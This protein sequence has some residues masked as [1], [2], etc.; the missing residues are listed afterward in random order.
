MLQDQ[1][2]SKKISSHQFSRNEYAW[3]W[4]TNV[5]D[6]FSRNENYCR[7]LT[8]KRCQIQ[9]PVRRTAGVNP[10]KTFLQH[11]GKRRKELVKVP[12]RLLGSMF[13]EKR[14]RLNQTMLGDCRHPDLGLGA[15]LTL[16][17]EAVGASL[18]SKRLL[19][20]LAG[21]VPSREAISVVESSCWR[22]SSNCP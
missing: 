6:Q 17:S 15:W 3:R 13:T 12:A 1:A 19:S 21:A 10:L 7:N 16:T 22:H 11:T 9:F 20:L 18:G 8:G 5:A 2:I 4:A 14:N